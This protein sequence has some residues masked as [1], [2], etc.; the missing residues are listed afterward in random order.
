M[1]DVGEPTGSPASNQKGPSSTLFRDHSSLA[2]PS[3]M[4]RFRSTTMISRVYADPHGQFIIEDDHDEEGQRTITTKRLETRTATLMALRC[5][6]TIVNLFMVRRVY[7]HIQLHHLFE[8]YR[9]ALD[10]R[11]LSLS[12]FETRRLDSFSC[13]ALSSSST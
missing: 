4:I 11:F 1:L 9:S 12:F 3:S 6:Y 13:S 10:Y 7:C 2:A 8:T 5:T